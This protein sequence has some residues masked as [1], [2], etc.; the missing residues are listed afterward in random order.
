MYIGFLKI[1]LSVSMCSLVSIVYENTSL[2]D[3]WHNDESLDGVYHK[4]VKNVADIFECVYVY[5]IKTYDEHLF[6][7][8]QCNT[9]K[10]QP[11][12]LYGICE[13]KLACQLPHSRVFWSTIK[14]DT[15]CTLQCWYAPTMTSLVCLFQWPS[16]P[17]QMT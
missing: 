8:L 3:A 10:R 7:E 12:W 15:K 6:H 9:I 2:H 4:K 5:C 14:T 13:W 17:I 1:F 16:L 11:W